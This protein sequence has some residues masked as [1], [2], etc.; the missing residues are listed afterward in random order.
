MRS[1]DS[2]IQGGPR[3]KPVRLRLGFAADPLSYAVELGYPQERRTA[4]PLILNARGNGSGQ[5]LPFTPTALVWAPAAGADDACPGA[6][7][8]VNHGDGLFRLQ[9]HQPGLLR[10]LQSAELSDSTLRYL[11]LT[12]VLFSPRLPPLARLMR[13]ISQRTQVWVIAHIP[14]WIDALADGDGCHRVHLVRELGSTEIPE[15][16]MLERS[17]WRWPS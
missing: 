1:R 17:A 14:R 9:F 5:D 8:W 4:F 13:S 3:S 2:P 16:T 7:V 15:Q 6:Y 12:A 10:L 11:L